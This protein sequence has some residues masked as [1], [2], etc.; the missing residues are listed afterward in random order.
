MSLPFL[1]DLYNDSKGNPKGK[2]AKNVL[3][4]FEIII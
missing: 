1:N 4:Y 2:D 3:G